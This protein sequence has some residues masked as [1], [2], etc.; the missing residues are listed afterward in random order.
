MEVLE[1]LEID[2]WYKVLVYLGSFIFIGSLFLETIYLTNSNA[3]LLGLVFICSGL[4]E[5]KSQKFCTLRE[6]GGIIQ[7]PVRKIDL[8]GGFLYLFSFIFLILLLN[9]LIF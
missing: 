4:A 9:S 3:G 6:H 8:I 1:N 5:W 2:K 7:Y